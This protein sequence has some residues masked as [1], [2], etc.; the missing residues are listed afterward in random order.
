M[1]F[2]SYAFLYR[3]PRLAQHCEMWQFRITD[4]DHSLGF[5]SRHHPVDSH[6]DSWKEEPD[7]EPLRGMQQ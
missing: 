5:G 4:F 6:E 3:R 2:I 1:F 7:P